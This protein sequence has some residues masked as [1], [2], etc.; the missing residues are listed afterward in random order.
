MGLEVLH[1]NIGETVK[2]YGGASFCF[3]LTLLRL[4]V[5]CPPNS[6]KNSFLH[7]FICTLS[8]QKSNCEKNSISF[9]LWKGFWIGMMAFELW[10]N[11]NGKRSISNHLLLLEIVKRTI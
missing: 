9:F 8:I 6:F 5:V 1:G 2:H 4:V 10:S 11:G 7:S 3:G